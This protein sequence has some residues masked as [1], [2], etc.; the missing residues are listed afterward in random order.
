M[1]VTVLKSNI[2]NLNN[3]DI[4]SDNDKR[5]PPREVPMPVKGWFSKESLK[6]DIIF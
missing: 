1:A 4:N 2:K 6:N 3:G 5:Y